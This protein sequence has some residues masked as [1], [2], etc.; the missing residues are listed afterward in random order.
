MATLVQQVAD[1]KKQLKAE[2]MKVTKMEK[3]NGAAV[4]DAEEAGNKKVKDLQF[5]LD[6][7]VQHV[8]ILQQ[9][10]DE[11]TVYIGELRTEI[12][13]FQSILAN[14]AAV[15]MWRT[16]PELPQDPDYGAMNDEAILET[17]Y[18]GSGS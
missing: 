1:L 14:T 13:C 9:R 16:Q 12:A 7:A 4:H 10:T 3:K 15:S 8:D 6:A 11:Q 5:Q 18:R 2:R 17:A